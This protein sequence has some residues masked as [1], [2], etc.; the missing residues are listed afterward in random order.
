MESGG[1]GVLMLRYN[2]KLE[3][4]VW[5]GGDKDRADEIGLT[6][7]NASTPARPIWFTKDDYAALALWDEADEAAKAMLWTRRVEWEASRAQE[8]TGNRHR[9]PDNVSLYPYQEAGVAYALDR[10][11]A[12][13]GD[14]PGL[15]KTAQAIV[16]ANEMGA[17]RVLV[18]CPAA[19]RLQWANAI[20][21]WSIQHRPS[22][23]PIQKASDGMSPVAGWTIISYDLARG[24][25]RTTLERGGWDYVILDEA[26]YLKTPE[27][28]RTRALFGGGEDHWPGITANV[29]KI[30]ALTGTPLPNRPRECYTIARSLCWDALDWMSYEQFTYRFNPSYLGREMV[31]RL[32]ELQNRLRCNLMVRR[33]KS[34][35]LSQLP[36]V[37]YE[38]SYVETTAEVRRVL[39]AEAMID[40]DPTDLSGTNMAI[41]GEV[42]TVRRE[43]GEAMAPQVV[44]HV[45]DAL[46]GGV[47]KLVLFAH[48]RSVM[49]H[50]E[51]HLGRYGLVRIDGA[52]SPANRAIRIRQFMHNGDVRIIL[53]NLQSMGTGVDGLQEV[54]SLVIF[55]EASWVPGE[56]H[57][58]VDRLHRIG[59]RS[60]VLARFMV[61]E[62]SFA[63][64]V[65][66]TAIGKE[67]NIHDALDKGIARA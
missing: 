36:E 22:I 66:G 63:E 59:Q 4:F 41:Q 15:G 46:D 34:E 38:L 49:D 37:R 52:T 1:V 25:L 17:K 50:L 51:E 56:N 19:V 39:H 58:A 43:M 32:P 64:R 9:Q 30:V 53:G 24:S 18:V 45:K 3:A 42:S 29:G 44:A 11:H 23:Y 65:L 5:L 21:S 35:V 28:L 31:G 67:R 12:L 54:A 20:R 40:I 14:Q 2:P 48:H 55:A 13:L 60:A 62:G 6:Y 57:Q 7:S 61:A 27:A 33:L 16:I 26:H 47:D 10:R 8:W